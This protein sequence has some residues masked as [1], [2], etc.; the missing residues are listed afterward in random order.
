MGWAFASAPDTVLI[1]LDRSA[2]METRLAGTPRFTAGT[3]H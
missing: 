1:L 3:G 2:S